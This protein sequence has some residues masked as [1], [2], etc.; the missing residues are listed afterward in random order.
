MTKAD[1]IINGDAIFTG[2]TNAPISGAII[3]K[4]N[5][6]VDVCAKDDSEKYI[7]E[8]TE[9]KDF[10]DEL[11][12]PGFHD[13][14]IHLFLGS[15]YA[16]SVSLIDAKSELEV[17]QMVKEFADERPE[18]EWVFGFSW[19][20]IYWD[21]KNLPHRSTLDQL[22]PDRPV[23]LMNAEGHGAWLNSKALE[24]LGIDENTPTPPFGEIL[25][26]ENGVPTGVLY[27]TAIGLA[28]KAFDMSPEKGE[29]LLK[30]F[31]VEANKYGITSVSD[32]LPLTGYEL[33]DI[34]LYKAF[35]ERDELTVRIHFLTVMN[36]D[37]KAAKNARERFNSD[38]LKFS[39]LKQFLDGV[40]TTYT[41]LMLA[42][43]SDNPDTK[44]EP[45]LPP[46]DLKKWIKEADKEGF[47]IRLHACGDGAVQLGLDAYEEAQKANGARDSRHTIE[48]I[49]V[50]NPDDINRFNEL[51]VIASMQPEHLNMDEFADNEYLSRLGEERSALTWPIQ[52]LQSAGTKI[53]FGSDYPVVDINP[54][55]GVYRAVTRV[56]SDGEPVGGWNPSEKLELA[57]A[58]RHFTIGSAY[59][60]YE[61]STLGTLEKGKI[62]DITVLDRNLFTV[63]TEEIL[64]TKV[65]MTIMDGKIVY[66]HQLAES[67]AINKG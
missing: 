11:I 24:I 63:A 17:A 21:E 32:M 26:D 55:L 37:L 27:E 51:G 5:L 7:D 58:L 33:G 48:H 18:D 8:N 6:I 1:I 12:M 64:E 61:E 2:T 13:F 28:E 52:T 40:P 35:D 47:R 54:M 30:Q 39:G 19:Y 45:F 60:V 41:A 25:K 44:G 14:H 23:F 36:G 53:A 20:H 67:L 3:I 43:Y 50:I 62:A 56:A 34:E 16:D 22:I 57:D 9:V 4:D 38:K 66:S 46:A 31:L 65:K 49:E 59:G 29:R 42:P 10:K 15:L